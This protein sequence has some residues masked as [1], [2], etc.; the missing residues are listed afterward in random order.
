MKKEIITGPYDE[1]LGAK[2]INGTYIGKKKGNVLEFKGIPY[3]L[4]PVGALRWKEPIIAEEDE[5][6][7][8][9]Y[10]YGPTAIQTVIDTEKAS[11]SNQSED[12]LYLN[13]WTGADREVKGKPVMVFIHGGAYG[14]GGTNDPLYDGYNFVEENNNIVLVTIAYRIGI[15]GFLDLSYLPDSEGYERSQNLGLLDQI[16]ALRYIKRNIKS[17]GG[18]PNNIT[19]FGESA[20]GGS[21]SLLPLIPEAKGLFRRVIAESGSVAL[22]YS[23]RECK[24]LTREFLKAAHASTV[25]ELVALT[26]DQIKELNEDLNDDINYPQRDGILLPEDL[27]EAYEKGVGADVDML[28]GTNADEMRYWIK[29]IGNV[30]KY[31]AFGRFLFENNMLSLSRD[32]RKRVKAFM[33]LQDNETALRHIWDITEFYNEIIFRLPAIRQATAHHLNG[34]NTYMYYWSYPSAIPHLKACHAVELAYVFNNPEVNTYIGE[35]YNEELGKTV[36]KMWVNFAT[37]GN[38]S[39]DEYEWKKYTRAHRETMILGNDIRIENDWLGVYRKLLFPLLDHHFNG[40][41]ND[42]TPKVPLVYKTV[43]ITVL[44]TLA[45]GTG[46]YALVNRKKT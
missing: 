41:R 22:T 7:Y 46:I 40:Y 39:T 29:D 20:G 5:N 36:R 30:H 2:C 4:P 42:L 33:L 14:W 13:V 6:V 1:T 43:G 16:C 25:A 34:G 35:D 45:L 24:H 10:N 26:E 38:P 12:C 31:S 8:E 23:K 18:D 21:V 28:I 37:T 44:V 11:A 19:I 3:A 27:Y 9:A 15:L 32:D 17:F